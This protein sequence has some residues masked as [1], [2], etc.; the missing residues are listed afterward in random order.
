MNRETVIA[1]MYKAAELSPGEELHIP[2][3][4]KDALKA[5]IKKFR[6]ELELFLK[7]DPI[8]ASCLQTSNRYKDSRHWFVVKNVRA[9]PFIAFKKDNDGNTMK[10]SLI[11]QERKR[12]LHLMAE[13]GMTIAEAEDIEGCVLNDD[14][15]KLFKQ[16]E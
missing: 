1:W 6:R 2:C 5:L 8:T 12:R 7:L 11:E 4:S 3:E 9:N 10:V 16:G 14:E 15:R 13:D